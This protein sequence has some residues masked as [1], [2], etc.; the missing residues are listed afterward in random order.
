M[1]SRRGGIALDFETSALAL[2]WVAIVLLAF[3]MAGILRYVHLVVEDRN[4]GVIVGPAVG[5]KLASVEGLTNGIGSRLSLLMFLDTNCEACEWVLPQLDRVPIQEDGISIRALYRGAVGEEE[6][7]D[8]PVE[9]LQ[10]QNDI[11]RR[12]GVTATPFGLGIT[13]S[14]HVVA[15][16]VIGSPATLQSFV[17]QAMERS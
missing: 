16:D 2:S 11:F 8:S 13:P 15:A 1:T 10:K 6:L 12:L 17:A 4:K 3:S 7:S 9:V 14:G 5:T